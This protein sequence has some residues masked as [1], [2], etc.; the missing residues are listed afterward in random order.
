[1]RTTL[2]AL[3]FGVLT[4]VMAAPWSLHPATRVVIDNPDTHLYAWTL[5]WDAH[6]FATDP[7]AIF[8]ANIYFPTRTR[9]P[10]P[11]T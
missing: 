5:G 3:L 6:A 10:T 4:I 11:R 8:D 7:F 2:L 9:S 1:M